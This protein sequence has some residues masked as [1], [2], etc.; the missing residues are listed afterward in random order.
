MMHQTIIEY[1]RKRGGHVRLLGGLAVEFLCG[2]QIPPELKHP[3][4][5]IMLYVRRVDR[6]ALKETLAELGCIP[7]REFNLFNG[8]ERLVYY[9]GE[10]KV[11]IYVDKFRMY[12]TLDLRDRIAHAFYTV[13]PTDLLLTKLQLFDLGDDDLR[14][15]LGLLI[16]SPLDPDDVRAI[17]LR[18][19][20]KKLAVDW[21]FWRTATGTLKR[22]REAAA[23]LLPDMGAWIVQVDAKIDAIEAAIAKA[24]KSFGWRY[25]AIA[26]ER[27]AWHDKPMEPAAR[28]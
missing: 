22:A 28:D 10:T 15:I 14:D 16:T 26:G 4:D 6:R 8:L 5:D 7:A 27:V 19:L 21:G 23:R 17:D 20:A 13:P 11:D 18:Y 9:A 24:P 3:N 12:H 25:R 2:T 1:T